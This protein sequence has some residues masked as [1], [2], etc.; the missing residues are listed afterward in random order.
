MVQVLRSFEYLESQT[1]GEAVRVLPAYG[2]KA[3][4]LAGGVGLVDSMRRGTIEPEC[5]VSIQR[6]PKLDY[7]EGD[8]TR[9]LRIGALITLRSLE[10]SPVIH[11]DYPFLWEAVHQVASI[12]VKNMATVVGNLC[13][14]SPASDLVPPLTCFRCS[15]ADS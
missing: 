12:Q 15:V 11:R 8:G 14:A 3:K 5:V 1:I 9:G 6:I 10:L 2:M 4:L 13:V 7:I